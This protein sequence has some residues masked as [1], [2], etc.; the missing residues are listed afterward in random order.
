MMFSSV[1]RLQIQFPPLSTTK[2]TLNR[3]G[4]DTEEGKPKTNKINH[5]DSSDFR[6]INQ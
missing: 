2:F 6:A 4:G 1:R 5:F 3:V